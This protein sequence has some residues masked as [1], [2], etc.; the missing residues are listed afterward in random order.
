MPRSQQTN[1]FCRSP[2]HPD[3]MRH[4]FSPVALF[5]LPT[6][7]RT[8]QAG[9]LSPTLARDK[10][11]GDGYRAACT[12]RP[13][14]PISAQTGDFESQQGRAEVHAVRQQSCYYPVPPVSPTNTT[15]GVRHNRRH[16][17][18]PGHQSPA[19]TPALP[20]PAL[21]ALCKDMGQW[22]AFPGVAV[23]EEGRRRGPAAAHAEA[24]PV[25]HRQPV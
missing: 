12:E 24:V 17:L 23:Q 10:H 11:N 15:P 13:L 3:G 9:S 7:R 2:P 5:W 25:A 20:L 22:F 4:H 18:F 16:V 6:L 1:L 14:I 21:H 19:L 8:G